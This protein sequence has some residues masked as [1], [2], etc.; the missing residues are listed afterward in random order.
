MDIL[1]YLL[2]TVLA[3]IAFVHFLWAVG[4]TWPLPD[5]RSLARAVVGTR[6][7]DRMPN[8][9]A[10][11]F[12]G[13]AL[14][15]ASVWSILLRKI[16]DVQP[17]KL[18][19][20]G[21]GIV[22]GLIFLIRGVIGLLPAMERFTPEQPFLRLNRRYYSPLCLAIGLGFLTLVAAFPNWS[23]RLSGLW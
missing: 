15:G 2:A 13:F 21:V 5:E 23:W 16:L 19:I 9:F 20:V 8:R 6:E 17:P 11:A 7:V 22:L 3:L 1:S 12:V 14:L 18:A 10:S 4:I